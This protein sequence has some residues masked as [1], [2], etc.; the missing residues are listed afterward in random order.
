MKKVSFYRSG[1]PSKDFALSPDDLLSTCV[2][3]VLYDIQSWVFTKTV[4][5][6]IETQEIYSRIYRHT[7]NISYRDWV[8]NIE[9]F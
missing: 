8:T 2:W 9:M 4:E 3:P 7:L 1:G 6:I 5:K